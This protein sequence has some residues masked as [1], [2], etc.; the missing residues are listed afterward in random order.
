[1]AQIS[2]HLVTH[3]FIPES[4]GFLTNKVIV[5]LEMKN[6]LRESCQIINYSQNM[7]KGS[8]FHLF[9]VSLSIHL[10]SVLYIPSKEEKVEV[11]TSKVVRRKKLEEEDILFSTLN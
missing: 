3:V 5:D 6:I 10:W 1:M 7:Q 9:F 8:C 4:H 2:F 11:D